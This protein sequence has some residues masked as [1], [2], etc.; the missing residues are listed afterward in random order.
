MYMFFDKL[1]S[2][3]RSVPKS[4]RGWKHIHLLNI[5]HIFKN[6]ILNSVICSLFPINLGINAPERQSSTVVKNTD[7]LNRIESNSGFS[8]NIQLFIV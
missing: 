2:I 5:M 6:Y 7:V 8:Q 4:Y 1:L 3:V